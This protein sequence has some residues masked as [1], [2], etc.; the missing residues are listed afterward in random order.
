MN[1]LQRTIKPALSLILILGLI[2]SASSCSKKLVFSNSSIVPAAEGSVK[3]KK[4]KN[5]NYSIDVSIIRLAEPT[6]LQPAK[7]LYLVW[8][9]TESNGIKNLGQLK[10]S[11]S[12]LS[13]TL[14]ASLTTNSPFKPKKIFITAEDQA[15]IQYPGYQVV[16][17]TENF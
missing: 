2:F 7:A 12:L 11:S 15:D 6:K 10:S 14:K 8:M 17:S 9:D 16:L 3:V 1:T 5:N 13:K 4:D